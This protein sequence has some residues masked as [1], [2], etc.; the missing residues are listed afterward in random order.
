MSRLRPRVR[1]GKDFGMKMIWKLVPW[2][3]RG[4]LALTAALFAFL[5]LKYFGDP[6][7][8]T[9]A[10]SISLASAAAVT[11]M[12]VVGSMFLALSLITLFFLV[13][14]DR[15]KS[16]LRFVLTVVG[17]ITIARLYGV[18]VDGAAASTVTKLRT[19]IVLLGVFAAGVT[20]ETLRNRR[21]NN[22]GDGVHR[23]AIEG[24]MGAGR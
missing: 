8:T 2:M 19:E 17:T 9:A 10:D 6:V 13:S 24:E 23:P 12:R 18:V 21:R 5:G 7:G 20:L 16:G 14:Q 15:V 1:R 3:S 4:L 11:D 22:A